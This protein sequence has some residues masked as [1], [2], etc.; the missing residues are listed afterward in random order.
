MACRMSVGR[1]VTAADR[2][3]LETDT[4]VEPGIIALKA[5]LAPV[6]GSRKLKDLDPIHVRAARHVSSLPP[7][8]RQGSFGSQRTAK[9]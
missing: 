9:R 4:Q 5:L 7:R 2:S 8:Q 1:I 3:A 6:G